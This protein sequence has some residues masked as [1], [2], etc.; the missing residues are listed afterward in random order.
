LGLAGDGIE[1]IAALAAR[2]F[3]ECDLVIS[4]GGVSVGDHDFTPA[5]LAAAG[6]EMMVSGLNLKPG[7]ACAY[8]FKGDRPAFALSG[9]P[10]A[11]L[12]NFYAV[13]QPILRKI[14][15]HPSPRPPGFNARLKEPFGQP[16]PIPRLLAARA[17]F[18]DGE[19]WLSLSQLRGKGSLSGFIGSGVVAEIPAGSPALPAGATLKAWPVIDFWPV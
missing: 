19:L 14:C 16:S 6:A 10:A 7:G 3:T 1:E 18:I 4:S 11:A 13:V 17:L 9:N 12:I 8:G 15:G 2:G 5:A